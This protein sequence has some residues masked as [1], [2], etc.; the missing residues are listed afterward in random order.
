MKFFAFRFPVVVGVL[1]LVWSLTG[2][3]EQPGDVVNNY[4]EEISEGGYSGP[5][6]TEAV[7]SG[8]LS[9]IT[10]AGTRV[11][12]Y[13]PPE[14]NDPVPMMTPIVYVYPDEPYDDFAAAKADIVSLGLNEI[15]DDEKGVVIMVNPV[16]R[17]WGPGD[18]EV[19]KA[20]MSFVYSGH[21]GLNKTFL[22]LQ[23]MIGEGSG[24]DFIHTYMTV[25][26]ARIAAVA[27]FGGS[28]VVPGG[29]VALPAYLA[30]RATAIGG[31][32]DYTLAYYRGVNG[33]T[34]DP[35]TE[36]TKSIYA[37]VPG[38]GGTSDPVKKVIVNNSDDITGFTKDGISDAYHSLFRYTTRAALF[39]RIYDDFN[40][41]EVF[42]LLP[43][44][45]VEELGLTMNIVNEGSN[46]RWYEWVPNEVLANTASNVPLVL[47]LHGGGDHE[48]YEAESN[49]WVAMA[50]E[51]RFIVVAPKTNT[52]KTSNLTLIND[53]ITK[54]PVIDKSRIYVTG[55][56]QGSTGLS[57]TLND[58]AAVEQFAAMALFSWGWCLSLRWL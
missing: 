12:V 20:L 17:S 49:G 8:T 11:Y 10:V 32:T 37:N 34:G 42:T 18:V 25:N 45:N 13:E 9:E 5:S 50:R 21:S 26:A 30:G 43:R 1:C 23:Y 57:N 6:H 27:T 15:A 47:V 55:F 36:G 3:G 40:T 52:N 48:V 33:A 38:R 4:Y 56:S 54:Y 39:T 28:N 44:P 22:N 53:M 19:Y 16:G 51:E 58:K 14:Y 7:G 31:G 24:A 41:P 46:N 2:C 29:S 35:E